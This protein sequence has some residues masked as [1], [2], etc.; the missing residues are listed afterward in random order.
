MFSRRVAP[1]NDSHIGQLLLNREIFPFSSFLPFSLPFLL[2]FSFFI[3]SPFPFLYLFN[4]WKG[5]NGCFTVPLRTLCWSPGITFRFINGRRSFYKFYSRRK[6][7]SRSRRS[8]MI[9]EDAIWVNEGLTCTY[10]I[11]G[12]RGFRASVTLLLYKHI[13]FRPLEFL[14]LKTFYVFRLQNVLR[15]YRETLESMKDEDAFENAGSS[16]EKRKAA[17]VG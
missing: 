14:N 13:I 5:L 16:R 7:E 3:S 11:Q 17:L 1:S 6:R 8:R 10:K 4:W 2:F 9:E 12:E 15:R